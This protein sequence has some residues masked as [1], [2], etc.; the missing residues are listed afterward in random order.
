MAGE[1]C[2]VHV[3]PPFVVEMIVGDVPM[4]PP[5]AIHRDVL[6]HDRPFSATLTGLGGACAVQ[7]EPPLVVA[8]IRGATALVYE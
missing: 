5:T 6:A 8:E 2:E 1:V 4:T 3:E 7:V